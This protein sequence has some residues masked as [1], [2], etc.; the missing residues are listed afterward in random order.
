MTKRE[1]IEMLS[2]VP[3]DSKILITESST[4]FLNS[5]TYTVDIKGFYEKNG[6]Y[7]LCTLNVRPNTEEKH[8]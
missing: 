1:L 5:S 6:S 4:G 2:S 7:I 8:D 3:D